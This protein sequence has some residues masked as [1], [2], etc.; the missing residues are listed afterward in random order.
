[1]KKIIYIILFISILLTA[2]CGLST[3]YYYPTNSTG[4]LVNGTI[5][6][7]QGMYMINGIQSNG[8]SAGSIINP[9]G[10]M[11]MYQFIQ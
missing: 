9:N 4:G 3:G 8:F 1:M 2:N 10:T 7:P 6:T 5:L 11:T